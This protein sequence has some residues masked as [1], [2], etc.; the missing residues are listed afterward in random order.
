MLRHER[1]KLLDG[2]AAIG[3]QALAERSVDPGPRHCARAVLR[4]PLLR[5]KVIQLLHSFCRFHAALVE[6]GL[7]G[8]DALLHR[9]RASND[10]VLIGHV[11]RSLKYAGLRGLG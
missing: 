1:A 9:G 6:R 2:G 11:H 4:N 8:I 3:E 10:G 7:D 5:C